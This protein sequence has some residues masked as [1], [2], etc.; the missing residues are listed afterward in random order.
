MELLARTF[1]KLS[2]PSIAR[3]GSINTFLTNCLT[4]KVTANTPH[5]TRE[6]TENVEGDE[7]V[8]VTNIFRLLRPW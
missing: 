3:G 4:N 1:K 2:Q 8:K 6:G 5:T 7:N